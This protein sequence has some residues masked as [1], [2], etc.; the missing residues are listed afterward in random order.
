[1][2]FVNRTLGVAVEATLGTGYS[3]WLSGLRCSE[4]P[5]PFVALLLWILA[6]KE[7][8]TLAFGLLTVMNL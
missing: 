1:M 3:L 2:R 7:Q 8:N 4:L 6:T 5:G